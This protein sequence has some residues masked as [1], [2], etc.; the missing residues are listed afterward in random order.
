MVLSSLFIT[1]VLQKWLICILKVDDSLSL[2][3]D[4]V[5]SICLFSRN[6]RCLIFQGSDNDNE[7]I[8]VK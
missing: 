1:T 6:V 7:N 4:G 2:H 3:N 5:I 8:G